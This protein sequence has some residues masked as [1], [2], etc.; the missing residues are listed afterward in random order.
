MVSVVGKGQALMDLVFEWDPRKARG[1]VL[2]HG[3]TLDE[4]T[5][6]FRDVLSVT[7]GDP[8]HSEDEDRFVL[9][10]HS[11]RNRLLVVVHTDRGDRVRIISARLAT[12]KERRSYEEN[13]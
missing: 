8:L 6:V 11:Y 7:I 10:G 5:T 4:A 13:A 2:K 9:I 12:A 1:N 3:V